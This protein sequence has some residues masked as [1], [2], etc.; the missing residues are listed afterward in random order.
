MCSPK[1]KAW[2]EPIVLYVREFH[3]GDTMHS[4]SV[5]R[6]VNLCDAGPLLAPVITRDPRLGSWRSI[7]PAPRR[8]PVS[9]TIGSWKDLAA[10]IEKL[11]HQSTTWI[12]RGEPS[13]TYEL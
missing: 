1:R 11:A 7:M 5:R 6:V 12:F 9:A 2:Q 4:V 10:L 8:K 13:D 3:T